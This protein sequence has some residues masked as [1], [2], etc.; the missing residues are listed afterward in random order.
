VTRVEVNRT[1][2]CSSAPKKFGRL[3]MLVACGAAG[4]DARGVDRQLDRRAART[5]H[6][7]AAEALEP[8]AYGVQVPE[9]LDLELDCRPAGVDC[10]LL[11]RR[12][13]LCKCAAHLVSSRSS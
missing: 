8:A 4:V 12:L 13:H 7:R 9:M 1:C 2:G 10:P 6:V 3:E 11:D 5:H